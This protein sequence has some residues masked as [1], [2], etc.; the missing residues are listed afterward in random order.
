MILESSLRK[1]LINGTR[2]KTSQ[3]QHRPDG[4]L[5]SREYWFAKLGFK[6]LND[7]KGTQIR[8]AKKDCLCLG[9]V[10]FLCK[11]PHIGITDARDSFIAV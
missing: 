6:F 10:D 9:V 7:I 11:P 5:V 4:Y 8:A 2:L 1:K 3:T